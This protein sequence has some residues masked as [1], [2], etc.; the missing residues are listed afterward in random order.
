VNVKRLGFVCT[1]FL[2][3][4]LL[5][6]IQ[7]I[8]ARMILPAFGGTAAVWTTCTLFF[9]VVLLIGYLY[10]HLTTLW[11][12]PSR[13]VWLHVSLLAVSVVVLYLG[14]PVLKNSGGSHPLPR[15]LALLQLSVGLPY[16]ML[17]TTGPLVQTWYARSFGKEVPYRLFALSNAAS[18]GALLAYPLFF[19][20]YLAL[21]A[22]NLLWKWGYVGFAGLCGF[23]AWMSR[24]APA[25]RSQKAEPVAA[26]TR[27]L[28]LVLAFCP[29]VLW[30]AVSNH[31]SQSVAA[32]P[33]L[34]V[35]P[36]SIYLLSFVLCFERDGW[37]RPR[38]F[39]WLL[40]FAW[41]GMAFG[42]SAESLPMHFE[43]IFIIFAISLLIIC[44]FCHGELAAR[45]PPT[46]EL[47]SFYLWVALGG[48]L[49][50]AFV[51]VVAPLVFQQYFE[52]PIGIVLSVLIGIALLY[53]A[54]RR[55][56][57]RL[58]ITCLA[59]FIY[60][61]W[62]S[63]TQQGTRIVVRNFYGSLKV[64]DDGAVE[65]A[66]RSLINGRI[67]HGVQ[68]MAPDRCRW[69]TTYYAPES[70]IG[71]VLSQLGPEPA[72]V[73][74]IGLGVGTVA[75]YGRQGD[76]YRF[77]EINPLVIHLANNEFHFL[78]Q[79]PARH[80]VIEG[81]GRLALAQD[82]PQHFDVLILD[83][84]SGDSIPIHLLTKEAFDLY[85]RN[86]KPD[87]ILAIHITNKYLD[88]GRLVRRTADS[89]HRE[90]WLVTNAADPSRKVSASSW[91]ILVPPGKSGPL[92]GVAHPIQLRPNLLVWT[93][94]FNN[95]LQV[96][97]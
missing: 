19:E 53:H 31:L 6:L 95:L 55:V 40:V 30:L 9:Q 77:Y 65:T 79:T 84:F 72:R 58:V 85:M 71:Q 78:A 15:I 42:I 12:T 69:A 63:P 1:I 44:I 60:A 54:S 83:A 50:S 23:S 51:A 35:L 29:A 49:G 73:G 48:A 22:Q 68:W 26:S 70:G 13:Q 47:T 91:V 34:W 33:F 4:T 75:A 97:N 39:R 28:W 61:I 27:L 10:A 5:F 93:D 66:S 8:V 2:S 38:L 18:L 59:G 21:Q 14:A 57:A 17:S 82:P 52:L 86:L 89:L 41:A 45:K 46:G 20:P 3:S 62:L 32:V 7:P 81:D 37:Y 64:V 56:M 16:L 25:K 36:L 90:A 43:W 94:D 24:R 80:D 67:L 76:Y 88:L 92:D 74:V 87:G 96:L 11:L